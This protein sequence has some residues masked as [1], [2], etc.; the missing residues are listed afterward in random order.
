[1]LGTSDESAQ[2][3]IA[4]RQEEIQATKEANEALRTKTVQEREACELF[5]E[6]LADIESHEFIARILD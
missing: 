3:P 5:S 6:R 2:L 4:T 1:M